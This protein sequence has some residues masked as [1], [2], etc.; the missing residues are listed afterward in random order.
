MEFQK[1]NFPKK[2][3]HMCKCTPSIRTPYCGAPHCTPDVIDWR[4][5]RLKAI[6]HSTAGIAEYRNT[7]IY[8]TLKLRNF[9]C[10]MMVNE[11]F[12]KQGVEMVDM[13]EEQM[14]M[15]L[16]IKKEKQNEVIRG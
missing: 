12:T 3:F 16:N 7:P 1:Y 8:N 4:L 11:G 9:L 10:V 5:E 2:T 6:A 15:L 13:L 14:C